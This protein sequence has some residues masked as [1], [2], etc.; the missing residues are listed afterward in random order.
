MRRHLPASGRRLVIATAVAG[1]ALLL[2]ASPA[3][4]ADAGTAPSRGTPI[5]EIAAASAVAALALAA[6]VVLGVMHRRRG[7]LAPLAQL[8]E[9]RTGR[10]AWAVLPAAVTG[11]SL[12]IAVFGYYWDVSWHIDRGRDPGAFA[13]PAHWFIIIGLDGIAFAGLL[14]LLLG[15][16]R[17]P[18]AVRIRGDWYT[19]VGGVLL[20]LCGVVALAG[21]PLD[22]IWH[23]L[24]GQD[25]TAWGPTHIQMIGGAS[26]ATLAVW[27]LQIE[28]ARA[29]GTDADPPDRTARVLDIVAGGS[30]LIGLSTLQVEFDFGVPQFQQV[31]HPILIMLAAGIGLVALRLRAGRGAALGAALF[32]LAVRGTLTALIGPVLGRSTQHFPL[33]LVE[34]LCVEAA[35][36]FVR[37]DRQITLGLVAGLGI[38][39]FGLASE[40][41]WSRA[42]MP[43]PWNR[44]ML[45]AALVLAPLAAV[46]AGVIGGLIG[47][48]LEPVDAPRQ[49]TPRGLAA[50]AWLAVAVCLAVPLRPTVHSSWSAALTVQP[51]AGRGDR[52]MV[53]ARMNPPSAANGARWFHL[54][55]WQ[56]ARKGDGG[57]EIV[58]LRQIAPG[59]WQSTRAVPIHGT[60]KTLLRLHKG[61]SLQAL[62]V[63]LPPDRAIPAAE[64]AA[65]SATRTFT[66]EK[67]ILQRE[68]TGGSNGLQRGAYALLGGIAAAWLLAMGWGLRRLDP[69]ARGRNGSGR[70]KAVAPSRSATTS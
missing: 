1:G 61:S 60:W 12:L 50:A 58:G 39:T 8:V 36:R 22:D 31:F 65:T 2:A 32:F 63:Y 45:P 69:L 17:S 3:G 5:G 67:A 59:T 51:V 54:L 30:F 47:R 34:A 25:V 14:A 43:L 44:G 35:A 20:A 6:V 66:D 53:T 4:A 7:I 56:G 46:A 27:T 21:F 10:P 40:W 57:L 28:G 37:R 64:V 19:P 26:L 62:P 16:R 29:T 23:R 49:P 38:G 18:Y 42:W 55:S 11:T 33:F 13:N 24:F 70:A 15:D 41:A 68:A 52:V 48:A 9:E